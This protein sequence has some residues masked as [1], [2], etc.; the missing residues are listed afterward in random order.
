M[1]NFEQK[2]FTLSMKSLYFL[3]Y[4]MITAIETTLV[5]SS[6]VFLKYLNP[7]PSFLKFQ[8]FI[9]PKF[10]SS[11]SVLKQTLLLMYQDAI[12]KL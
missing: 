4:F 2:V 6:I 5:M 12:K 10:I 1:N 7:S 9:Y 3:T 8:C 11:V